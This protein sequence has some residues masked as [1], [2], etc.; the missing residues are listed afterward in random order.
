MIVP[1]IVRFAAIPLLAMMC[2]QPALSQIPDGMFPEFTNVR[3]NNVSSVDP[4]E[5]S[6]AINPLDPLNLAAGANIRYYY[7]STNGGLTWTQGNLTSTYGV[8]GDPCLVF[9][10]RGYLY[11]GHLSNPPS[12]GYWIDRIV[13][14]RSTTGGS[15]WNSGVGVGFNPPVRAQDKEWIA[16]DM[17]TSPYRHNL[18]MAWTEFDSY[19]ST[20]PTDSTRI[21][22]SRST[23][24]GVTWA[25]PLRLSE[26]GG[27]CVD[28]DN[29]VEGAVPAVGPNGE[30]Y[31]AWSGPL[32]IMFDRS[33]DGGL[34]FGNDIFVTTQPGG[35]DFGVPGIYRCNG[36]P[37]TACDVSNSPYR[38]H[39]YV[40]W[41]DQ[42]NGLGDTEVFLIKSTDGGTTWGSTR[43]VN[44]DLTATQQFFPWM[45]IDQST[46]YVYAVFYD[47]RNTV[48]NATEVWVARSTDGGETFS[49][50]RVSQSAFT[51]T[52]GVFFGDYTNIAAM[53]GKVYPIWMRLDGSTL[54][55]WTALVTDSAA[56]TRQYS[57][58]H[59]WNIV[60]L[61]M[62]PADP[63]KTALFPT[64]ISEAYEYVP[65]SGYEVRDTLQPGRAYWLRFGAAQ[66]LDLTGFP[67]ALDTIDVQEGWNLI[68]SLDGTLQV[69]AVQEIPPGII[70]S[71]WFA[72]SDSGY[73]GTGTIE[74]ARG[75]W[76][77]TSA[78][79]KLVLRLGDRDLAPA[80]M[81][82]L[83]PRP[84]R[85]LGK[86]H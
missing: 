59:D 10:G 53:N 45:T 26:H 22:F 30:I 41:S 19:G 69:G 55:V 4:E 52:P 54:S 86:W 72:Y 67:M 77:K 12:P 79:G 23:D 68:G 65:G 71:G 2:L 64:A 1:R 24:A 21:L 57:V 61:P 15:S 73:L 13:V 81:P 8:W 18:Y 49:N 84:V 78:A 56:V 74:A 58:Q 40:L 32:G 44:N 51:P 35:W 17:T 75:Y 39:V 29:T 33:T 63:R 9:D 70:E 50:F 48:G 27:D 25:A 20:S 42:R 46:G 5:V 62:T 47:R 11:F 3:I 16:A 6:I 28:E 76:V 60:S 85:V 7:H 31:T 38:G 36:M 37:V 82:S 80:E 83:Q 34:T 66:L 43:R 14:N